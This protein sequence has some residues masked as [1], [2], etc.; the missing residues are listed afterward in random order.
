MS[1]LQMILQTRLF[2]EVANRTW[3]VQAWR[4]PPRRH[5]PTFALVVRKHSGHGGANESVGQ[6]PLWQLSATWANVSKCCRVRCRS[7]SL[8]LERAVTDLGADLPFGQ[9]A[10]KSRSTT[11]LT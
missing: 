10:A 1:I 5:F 9:V 3:S 2:A 11:V 8:P 6:V 4:L 7:H